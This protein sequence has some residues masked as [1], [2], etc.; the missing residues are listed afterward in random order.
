M[1]RPDGTNLGGRCVCHLA[2]SNLSLQSADQSPEGSSNG[3]FNDSQGHLTRM[4]VL[5]R[6]SQVSRSRWLPA[7]SEH[8]HVGQGLYLEQI[9]L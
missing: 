6:K 9:L 2:R 4:E 3:P 1:A 7:N 8:D 5:D